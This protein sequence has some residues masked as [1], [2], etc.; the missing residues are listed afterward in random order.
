MM[1]SPFFDSWSTVGLYMIMPHTAHYRTVKLNA[2]M[3]AR[4]AL[5]MSAMKIFA[6]P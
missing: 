6:S 5:Y 4:C 2:K 3:T 1:V